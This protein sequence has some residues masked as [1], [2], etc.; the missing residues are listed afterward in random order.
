[1]SDQRTDRN[2]DQTLT[3]WMD[4]VAPDRPPTRLLEGTFAQ[5]MRSPQLRRFP[6]NDVTLGRLGWTATG[7]G[8]R[9]A[10]V[11]LVVALML[12]M[13]IGAAGGL[14]FGVPPV[15]SPSPT[16]TLR[17]TPTSALPAPIAVTPESTITAQGPV[18]M[19][20][21][22]GAIWVM[23]PGRLDRID[24]DTDEVGASGPLGATTELYNGLAA[25]VDGLWATNSDAALLY[26]VDPAT[27]AVIEIPA[28]LAPKGVL[29][30]DDAVW[31]ADVHGGS[32]LRI[33][34]ATNI[35]AGTITVGPTGPSGPNWLASG[36]GSIWVGV[37]NANA[38]VRID[39]ATDLIQ[40]TIPMRVGVT[41]CGGFAVATTAVWITSCSVSARIARIDPVSNTAVAT[42]DLGGFGYNPTLIDGAPW[43]S[44]DR[45]SA[46][47]GML[48]RIDPATN[49]VDQVLVPRT[50]FGG[51]GDI[52]VAAGSVWVMD[53]YNNTVIRLPLTDFGPPG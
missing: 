39:P 7:S 29:A 3:A 49:T 40:A 14:R 38:I 31:V 19:V 8:A 33:D 5:T 16:P 50:R 46:D 17:P 11:V 6:W 2:I 22:D 1:M 10:L 24:P 20:A 52:V 26:R 48:V 35:V 13:L 53:G 32:V 34:P 25:S 37:P 28:G 36:L 41:P 23:A 27:L 9:I 21:L 43:V 4:Q 12:A 44:V 45:G 42:V 47:S 30:A 51:G 18:A 15:P